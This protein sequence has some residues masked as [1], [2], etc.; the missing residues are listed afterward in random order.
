MKQ[1]I[2]FTIYL[3][4][5]VACSSGW[6]QG[7]L[8][9]VVM[10]S[11][12]GETLPGAN[13]T[14]EGTALGGASNIDGEFRID[15]I[16]AGSYTIES[17]YIGYKS[18][19]VSV[20]IRDDETEYMV[21]QIIPD[22]IEGETIYITAQALGQAAA[23]NQQ[24]RSNTIINVVSEEKIQELPDA[25]AAESIGRLPGVSLIRSGGEANRIVMRG[26]SDKYSTVTVNGIRIAPT[27]A[28]VRGLDL[29]T[30]SQG[31]L[32]GIELYK[33]LTPD[34]DADAIAGSVNLVTKK[35]PVDRLLRL[36][37]IGSYNKLN[38]NFGQYDLRFKYGDRF[39]EN[40]TLGIQV[41]GNIEQR[42]RS[43]EEHNL[44][45]DLNYRYQG[46]PRWQLDGLDLTYT[47]ETRKR[48]GASVL[49]DFNT[50]DGGSIR[51][52]NVYNQ[53]NRDYT[54]Y[55][56]N[57]IPVWGD[58]PTTYNIRD[59]EQKIQAYTG[60]LTGEN[61]FLGL[62]S[63]WG[64][65][66]AESRAKYPFDY[67]MNFVEPGGMQLVPDTYQQGPPEALI[68]YANNNFDVTQLQFAFYREEQNKDIE[69][70]L[71][72]NLAEDYVFDN[73]LSGNLKLGGKY[74]I[75]DRNKVMS[76]V[77]SPYYLYGYAGYVNAGGTYPLKNLAGTRFAALGLTEADPV[78]LAY[79]LNQ[80]PEKREIYDKYTL[81]PLIDRDAVRQWWNI[82]RTGYHAD[83]QVPFGDEYYINPE[84]EGQ[85]YNL[86]E[87]ISSAFLMNTFNYSDLVTF[88]AGIRV[89]HENNDYDGKFAK[90]SS[91]GFP[92]PQAVYKDTSST[93]EETI[94]L[95]NF[96]ISVRPLDIM[97]IRLAAYRALARP[98]FNN[99]L[100]NFVVREQSYA[101]GGNS[102]HI[103]NSE[104]KALK[105]WNYEINVSVFNNTIGLFSVSGFY[106][107]VSDNILYLDNVNMSSK[108]ELENVGIYLD[109][110]MVLPNG[111]INVY[112]PYNS[113]KKAYV[114]GIEIEHQANLTFLPGYLRNIVLSYNLS[115]I[116]S[117]TYIVTSEAYTVPSPIPGLPPSTRY[118]PVERQSKMPDQ[119]D[120]FANFA[121]GY[122]IG[123]FSGR[124]SMFH[125]GEY[126]RSFRSLNR[127]NIVDS[128]T[129]WDVA[130]KYQLFRNM[131]ILLN[132][133]NL[134]NITETRSEKDNLNN[135]HLPTDSEK[136]GMTADVGLRLTL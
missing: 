79:F 95:P 3:M 14:I 136:Y 13:I 89:E 32:A 126:I 31:S 1:K 90:E 53:T 104:L 128:F 106:K 65:S 60:S 118:H 19:R 110:A 109:P 132:I 29:S 133:N 120:F 63:E 96:H 93:H 56:R 108:S 69:K 72:L 88:I 40:Q 59:R 94:W 55:F 76:E 81:Y 5:A 70:N 9:G 131:A 66:Y 97:T 51:L 130:L 2:F 100:P 45:N 52:N 113:P 85:F 41:S 125:Q 74:R 75:K 80:N 124:V 122:D 62:S 99:R 101:L 34:K 107:E 114:K 82:N 11:L 98:D 83:Q 7:T 33:A 61:Y 47:D 28:D 23:I 12:T 27:D 64:L 135:W 92:I 111:I 87:R 30:I 16:P 35:A 18:V 119:P 39:L 25:N 67:E 50:P 102:V 68:P 21:A 78:L 86:T 46:V 123:D 4:I 15:G 22:I 121:I 10:D 77:Y 37:A 115:F 129:R 91:G 26:L 117:Q 48:Y 44:D 105:A 38:N 103:G 127:D 8:T 49:F 42:D 112:Y 116:E 43:R 24:V 6:T 73:T 54:T 84:A 36:D 17:S 134:T 71:Y 58:D 57:Y 20:E